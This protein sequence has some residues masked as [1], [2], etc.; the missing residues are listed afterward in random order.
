MVETLSDHFGEDILLLD[1][2]ELTPIADFFVIANASSDR[3]LRALMEAVQA[4]ENGRSPRVEGD[5]ESGWV[6]V[7][8]GSVITHLFSADKR[9][10]FRLED[11]WRAA[12]VVVRLQ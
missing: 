4:I 12:R 2:M 6:L 10:F 8:H 7:D 11:V 9:S 1:I 5:P 3:Q